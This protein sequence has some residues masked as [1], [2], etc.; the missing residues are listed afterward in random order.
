MKKNSSL[1]TVKDNDEMFPKFASE[2]ERIRYMSNAYKQMS[3]A[4]AFSI[5]YNT[6]ISNEVKSNHTINTVVI[7][8]PGE[9]YVGSVKEFTERQILFDIP[10]IKDDIVCKEPLFQNYQNVQNFLLQHDN[11]LL[12][13]VLRKENG[14]F[15]VS[16]IDAYYKKWSER[17]NAAAN[18]DEAVNVHIDELVYGGY[19]C[20]TEILPLVQLTGQNY[21]S[22]VFI[23]GSHIVLNIENDFEKWIGKDVQIIPQKFV[24]RMDYKTGVKSTFLVGSRKRV[25]QL[26]GTQY[27]YDIYNLHKLGASNAATF[28][29]PSYEGKVTGIINSNKKTGVF[30]ELEDKYITGLLPVEP[31]DLLDYKVGDN[32]VVK[33]AEF[34]TQ[35]GRDPFIV[36]NNKVVKC[37][38]RP[39]FE[40]A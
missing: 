37:N 24:E 29:K 3:I 26:L 38:V 21:I 35:E 6:P 15:I 19:I 12:F 4:K 25:L 28:T 39:V 22:S 40:L 30:I 27:M 36:K 32:V 11:Q 20:H 1:I 18:G 16:V 23:P 7:L 17:L 14:K 34:E 5:F 10:G 13:K 33:F 9:I 8:E 2:K 31:S